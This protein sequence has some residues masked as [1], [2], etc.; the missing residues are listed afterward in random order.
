MTQLLVSVRSAMEAEAA[1]RGGAAL[2]DVKEPAHGSLGRASDDV[3]ADVLRVVAN[4][5]PVSAALGELTDALAVPFPNSLAYVKWGLAGSASSWPRILHEATR[6][7][8]EQLPNGRAVAVAY[9]DWQ[10][11]VAPHPQDICSF[12]VEK[13]MGAF[14]VDTWNKDGSTLLDWLPLDEIERLR[15]RCRVAGIPMALAGSLGAAEIRTLLRLRPDWFA[16]RGAV[17]HGRQRGAMVD[18]SKVR[19][20]AGLVR[21]QS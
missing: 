7:M 20:L 1:L 9:A 13:P 5:R 12:A 19:Q 21:N 10:R 3:I 2:I 11:A 6:R 14:L 18:E 17:C 15:E 16:V 8:T 4:R